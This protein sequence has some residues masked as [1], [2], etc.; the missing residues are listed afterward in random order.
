M[1][2]SYVLLFTDLLHK[3]VRESE[4]DNR[5]I[6]NEAK[7]SEERNNTLLK[8]LDDMKH[9]A[10]ELQVCTLCYFKNNVLCIIII[11]FSILLKQQL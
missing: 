11:F 5:L 9:V 6:L 7:K 1:S 8:Q 4:E 10:F 3:K 2:P